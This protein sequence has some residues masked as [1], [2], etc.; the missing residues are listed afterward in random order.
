MESSYDESRSPYLRRKATQ[1]GESQD[2]PLG[3]KMAE[4]IKTKEELKKARESTMQLWLDSK[5]LIDELE[6]LKSGLASAENQCA[7]PNT[8]ISELKSQLEETNTSI[9]AK[10]E[11]ELEARNMI[12]ETNQAVDQT[13]QEIVSINL[14]TEEEQKAILRMKQALRLRRQTLRTLQ[15]TIRAV[16]I[17]KDATAASAAEALQYMNYSDME[18]PTVNISHEDYPGL[19]KRAHDEISL[20]DWRVL[21][22]A[23]QK[24]A[25][26][27]SRDE[28][29]AKLNQLY[30]QLR[31]REGEIKEED[32][33]GDEQIGDPRIGIEGQMTITQNQGRVLRKQT[34]RHPRQQRRIRRD[35]Y[36]KLAAKMKPSYL[37]QIKQFFG[38]VCLRPRT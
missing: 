26:E 16:R 20:S 4:L 5:P 19:T 21:V 24:L 3:S 15:L 2:K 11:E 23:E 1:W 31:S 33:N 27:A 30:S 28:A 17:E 14:E 12:D 34:P 7:T 8:M 36:M 6:K 9:K 18:N 25:A 29:L 32:Y 13:R 37:Q 35:N 10:K 38:S 22:C